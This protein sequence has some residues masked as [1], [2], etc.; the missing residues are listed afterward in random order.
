[1][2]CTP[3]MPRVASGHNGSSPDDLETLPP[4]FAA[5]ACARPRS[6]SRCSALLR[7]RDLQCHHSDVVAELASKAWT[8]G[9]YRPTLTDLSGRRLA[10]RPRRRRQSGAT[11]RR[12]EAQASFAP[13]LRCTECGTASRCCPTGA[14][15]SG[16]PRSDAARRPA[17]AGR[18]LRARTVRRL[19]L[20]A[21]RNGAPKCARRN[22]RAK[23]DPPTGGPAHP[24]AAR[25]RLAKNSR[26][27]SFP[28]TTGATRRQDPTIRAD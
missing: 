12:P 10:R 14:G 9:D 5:P 20:A 11:M 21:R 19:P 1:M 24:A 18:G 17:Q 23:N 8:R 16:H 2:S 3:H 25:P 27:A 6:G 7:A 15:S 4:R 28:R 13:A 22:R 26:A